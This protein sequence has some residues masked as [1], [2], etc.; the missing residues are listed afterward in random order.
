MY[1]SEDQGVIE[2]VGDLAGRPPIV[3]LSIDSFLEESTLETTSSKLS[4]DSS[5]DSDIVNTL[6]I[7]QRKSRV[8]VPDSRYTSHKVWLNQLGIVKESQG[9]SSC[10]TDCTS[11][12][13]D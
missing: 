3:E 12:I 1:L 2:L 8:P 10:V 13:H 6:L 9:I 7:V 11:S 4:L 5:V